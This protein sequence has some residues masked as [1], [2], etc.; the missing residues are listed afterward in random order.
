MGA[1]STKMSVDVRKELL[2]GAIQAQP[3][4]KKFNTNPKSTKSWSLHSHC[5][6][7]KSIHIFWCICDP[8]QTNRVIIIRFCVFALPSKLSHLFV[9]NWFQT[10]ITKRAPQPQL[11]HSTV[12]KENPLTDR[13]DAIQPIFFRR[14]CPP[15]H[16]E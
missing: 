2:L 9:G 13:Q 10:K 16:S 1:P 5:G 14:G 15:L 4:S 11:S 12:S 7:F 3:V 8:K 6:H